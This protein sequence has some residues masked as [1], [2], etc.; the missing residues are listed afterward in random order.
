MVD[1][2]S[3]E[4]TA[5][6]FNYQ[7][8]SSVL[9][10]SMKPLNL[11]FYRIS[12][13]CLVWICCCSV[14]S[15]VVLTKSCMWCHVNNTENA[16]DLGNIFHDSAPHSISRKQTFPSQ[17]HDNFFFFTKLMIS[18]LLLYCIIHVYMHIFVVSRI[19]G[20]NIKLWPLICFCEKN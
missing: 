4:D 7:D 9:N 10:I 17:H 1:A 11:P 19:F 18:G 8:H 3:N 12:R 5:E 6:L 16:N 20:G 14:T 13:G 15:V 2:L